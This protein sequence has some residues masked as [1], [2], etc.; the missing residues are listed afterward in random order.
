MEVHSALATKYAEE[1]YVKD[2]PTEEDLR[3]VAMEFV[4]LRKPRW[5]RQVFR[6]TQIPPPSPEVPAEPTPLM[7]DP[8]PAEP[9]PVKESDHQMRK[10]SVIS[11]VRWD[12][13]HETV[14]S[15]KTV[16]QTVQANSLKRCSALRVETWA[17]WM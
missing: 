15:E 11:V 8:Q 1:K 9:M 2:P 3:Y 13:S 17:T 12:I 4:R 14:Q 6:P 16:I 10:S 5:E 7:V